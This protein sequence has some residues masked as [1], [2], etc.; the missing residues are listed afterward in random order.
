MAGV[1]LTGAEVP[2]L[3]LLDSQHRWVAVESLP[4]ALPHRD[5]AVFPGVEMETLCKGSEWTQPPLRATLHGVRS[6]P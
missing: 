6:P 5:V 3:M 4:D 2:G 1:L